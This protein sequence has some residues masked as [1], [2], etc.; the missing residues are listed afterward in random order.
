MGGPGLE[1]SNGQNILPLRVF[2][3]FRREVDENCALLGHY[4][5]SSGNL[6]PT[7]RDYLSGPIFRALLRSSPLLA[8]QEGLSSMEFVGEICKHA[9]CCMNPDPI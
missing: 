8:P 1:S 9:A 2:S 7:F 5:A 4:A 3:V 6:L